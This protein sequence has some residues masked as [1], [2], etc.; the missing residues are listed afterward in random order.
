MDEIQCLQ[1]TSDD[2]PLCSLKVA[3][4]RPEYQDYKLIQAIVDSGAADHVMPDR[5]LPDHAVVEGE[6][7]RQGVAY[8]TA[9]GSKIPNLGEKKVAYK[10]FEGHSACSMFQIADVRRAFLSVPRLTASGHDVKFQDKGGVISHPERQE[11]I[12]FKRQGGL[13][14]LDMWV[15]P[16]QRQG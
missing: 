7:K 1:R 8:T 6:A 13:Y 4:K 3:T 11:V 16:F 10:T 12:H 2:V 9:D 14:I 15:A 5:L